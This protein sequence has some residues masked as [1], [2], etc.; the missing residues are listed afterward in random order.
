MGR[1]NPWRVH[2]RMTDEMVKDISVTRKQME[3]IL[4]KSFRGIVRAFQCIRGG[5]DHQRNI[6]DQEPARIPE[7]T[8]VE[9]TTAMKLRCPCTPDRPMPHVHVKGSPP[10]HY[11]CRRC[12]R[13]TL[14]EIRG[15][16]G[17]LDDAFNAVEQFSNRGQVIHPRKLRY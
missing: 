13:E 17:T 14:A 12:G 15:P 11:K 16:K 9:E 1:M 10:E 7:Q 2:I 4:I 3:A 6:Q 8:G 5:Q